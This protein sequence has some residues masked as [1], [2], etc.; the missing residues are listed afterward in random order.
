MRK[1]ISLAARI[2]MAA[3]FSC[4]LLSACGQEQN[5]ATENT[6]NA[7]QNIQSKEGPEYKIYYLDKE[8]TRISSE[9]FTPVQTETKKMIDEFL[10]AME[11]DPSDVE[12]E[13]TMGIKI[14][15]ENYS[16]D[17][18]QVVLNFKE[19]YL[20][21]PKTTEILVRAA[22]VKTLNQIPGVDYVLFQ[23]NGEPLNDSSGNPIGIMTEDLF[24]D[25][26]GSEISSYE[27][28]VLNLYFANKSGSGLVEKSEEVVYNS[29]ISMEK[30]I[31]EK[32]IEG[33]ETTDAFPTIS[34]KTKILSVSVK[35]GIC[36]VDLGKE[37]EDTTLDV[38][39]EVAVYS[40]VNSLSELSD[41]N[42]VQI[43][44]EGKNDRMFRENINLEDVLERNLEI[45]DSGGK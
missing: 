39:E 9:K 32:I 8:E 36:Y 1:R 34:D 41:V 19:D 38:T 15:L 10:K 3:V 2:A 17:T 35:D 33:P 21:L 28:V 37:A 24:I 43:S 27:R 11:K 42:K 22:M 5:Q 16:Y 14:F 25:N 29:N 40:I 20:A 18:N 6:E 45:M 44:I 31:V 12:L 7:V 26:A 4:A 13:R 30:L 23:V